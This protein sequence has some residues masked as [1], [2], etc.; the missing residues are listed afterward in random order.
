M[1]LGK[2]IKKRGNRETYRQKRK[3]VFCAIFTEHT[4]THT[5]FFLTTL[6]PKLMLVRKERLGPTNGNRKKKWQ[7]HKNNLCAKV[8]RWRI[9]ANMFFP[10]F[11]TLKNLFLHNK[12]LYFALVFSVLPDNYFGN[13][14][15]QSS[16]KPRQQKKKC[17]QETSKLS[18]FSQQKKRKIRRCERLDP[19]NS[20][21]KN[22]GKT[23]KMICAQN[24][25][26]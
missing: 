21:R 18:A 3:I 11:C 4:H 8:C 1:I 23:T 26:P 15:H 17:V 13:K 24:F 7:N 10:Q 14:V 9:H 22:V 20:N 12:R 5:T 2:Y 16:R 6:F 25:C 19:R